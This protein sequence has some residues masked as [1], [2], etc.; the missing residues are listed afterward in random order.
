MPNQATLV[1]SVKTAIQ[2]SGTLAGLLG[3]VPLQYADF[4]ALIGAA[5]TSDTTGVVDATT[6]ARTIV[7]NLLPLFTTGGL[8]NPFATLLTPSPYRGSI[9]SSNPA[10]T[11][12]MRLVYKDTPVPSSQHSFSEDFVLNGT[13]PVVGVQPN[14]VLITSLAPAPGFAAPAGMVSLYSDTFAG[15]RGNGNETFR[16]PQNFQGSVFSD[17]PAD[18]AGGV[19]AHTLHITY[20]DL[21]L[22]GPFTVDIPLN[23]TTPVNTGVANICTISNMQITAAGANLGNLGT[24]T[25]VSGLNGTGGYKGSLAPSFYASFPPG[26]DQKAPFMGLFTFALSNALSTK[27]IETPP[28]IT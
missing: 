10:D 17:N 27:I 12:R 24:I 25:L 14:K 8:F 7:F 20:Q 6:A 1:Y 13:T 16:I 5:V 18:S 4:P 19:G 3:A 11:T 26:T 28:V 21:A 15:L 22:T 9:V 2:N 23:G